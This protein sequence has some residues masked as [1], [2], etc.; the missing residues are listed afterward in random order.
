M[1]SNPITQSV[2]RKK[3]VKSPNN[4]PTEGDGRRWATG[5]KF[6]LL[7]TRLPLWHDARALGEMSSFYSRITLLFIRYFTWDRALDPDGHRPAEAP[8]EDNLEQ[9]LDPKGLL[10]AEVERRNRIYWEV[11][12]VSHP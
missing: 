1:S 9:V 7:N 2:P 3:K 6:D 12:G 8:S 11:R 4:D 10:P 5:A